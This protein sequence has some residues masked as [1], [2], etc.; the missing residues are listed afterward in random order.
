MFL[1]IETATSRGLIALGHEGKMLQ[2][3]EIPL[4]LGNSRNLEPELERLFKNQKI[5]PKDLEFVA[6]GIGPGSYTG[7]RVGV[8]SAKALAFA[9][10][11]PL[12]PLDSL[13][14]FIPPSDWQGRFLAVIDARIGGVYLR[15]GADTTLVPFE[16]FVEKAKSCSCI[17]TPDFAPLQ[18][19]LKE[20]LSLQVFETGPNAATLCR[21][22][23]AA[24]RE[25][26]YSSDGQVHIAYLRLTQAE[27]EKNG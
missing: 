7:I 4:G 26:R 23:E 13:Q 17:V 19:R 5:Q 12:V 10:N 1:L 14:G 9:L 25:G 21:L 20:E 24:Y 27:S 18:K 6:V 22:A 16:V 15:D 8:A 2:A 3:A 11:L